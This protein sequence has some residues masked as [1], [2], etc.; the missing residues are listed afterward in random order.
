METDLPRLELHV[1]QWDKKKEDK[2][3]QEIEIVFSF[4]IV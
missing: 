4:L 2:N 1:Q 3:L